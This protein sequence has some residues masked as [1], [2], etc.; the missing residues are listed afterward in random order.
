MVGT[1]YRQIDDYWG[2]TPSD[3]NYT[4]HDQFLRGT[5]SDLWLYFIPE[6]LFEPMANA[7]IWK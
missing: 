3:A 7:I 1:A 6:G 4:F 5:D 2:N